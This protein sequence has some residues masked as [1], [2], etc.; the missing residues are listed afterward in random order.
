MRINRTRI[1]LLLLILLLGTVTVFGCTGAGV[2]RGWSGGIV[3]G[4]TLFV[5][6][7]E[8]K[9]IALD[10]SDGRRLG[11]PVAL[12]A[13]PSSS[14]GLACLPTTCAPTASMG[15]ALYSSPAVSG[16]LVYIGGYDGRVRAFLFEEDELWSQPRWISRE[17]DITGTIVG[18]LV[19]AQGNVY[20]GASDGKVYALDALDGHKK[21]EFTTGGK[22]W[23]T[24]AIN[25][26]TL[27][28]GSFDKKLYA[29]DTETGEEKWQQPF[30]TQGAITS[31]PVVYDNKVY[32]GSFD[33]RLYAVN[34]ITGEQIWRFP[35][36]DEDEHKPGN[37]FWTKPLVSDDD[38]VVVVYAACLDGK[39]YALDAE[40]GEK[41]IEF[42]L[43]SPI[44]SSPVLVG[45]LVIVATEEGMVYTLDTGS[46]N[47]RELKNLGEKVRAPLFA[48][49]GTVYL[50]TVEDNLYELDVQ[51][52][53]SRKFTLATET[54]Q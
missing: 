12:E 22:I 34:A 39:V 32:I 16:D 50:H 14:G 45:D 18:G 3:V 53:Q 29:L 41:V 25:G 38:D 1:L 20:F 21:W 10:I 33:R 23:S 47:K 49:E 17:G 27:F 51:S 28:I 4:D 15:V 52:G 42:D 31:T 54:S 44:S 30:E 11:D 9:L 19:V 24:P 5:G 46:N 26:D 7:M 2:A 48:S 13:E 40:S 6:S 8:G 43:G 36:T 37:W 35:A